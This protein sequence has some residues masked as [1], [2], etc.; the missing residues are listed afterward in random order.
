MYVTN[1]PSECD[2][3][4]NFERLSHE[5][6]VQPSDDIWADAGQNQLRRMVLSIGRLVWRELPFSTEV[7]LDLL[8]D[9][10]FQQFLQRV[11]IARNAE[12]CT[13]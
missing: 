8:I 6:L 7:F 12:C 5:L 4:P 2:R 1:C 13:S 9:H 3:R 10:H 11:R